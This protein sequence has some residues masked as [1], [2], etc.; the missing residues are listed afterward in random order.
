MH[1]RIYGV[2]LSRN[3]NT[4]KALFRSLIRS[5]VLYG[6]IETTKA[7][8]KAIQGD[9]DKLFKLVAK[10]DLAA[11]RL[12]LSKLGNDNVTVEKLFKLKDFTKNRK[13]G[14]TRIVILPYR[15]GDN[16]SIARLEFVD[17]AAPEEAKKKV[18]KK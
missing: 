12:A 9:V 8:A 11:R 4:R 15:K 14:F 17:S 18:E 1:K 16:A 7:K 3:T 10:D 13:S 5:L 2:K 6:K